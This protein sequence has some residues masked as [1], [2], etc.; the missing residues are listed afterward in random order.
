MISVAY[1]LW[2]KRKKI[3][4]ERFLLFINYGHKLLEGSRTTY[5]VQN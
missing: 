4:I 5:H 2:L 1:A 3:V